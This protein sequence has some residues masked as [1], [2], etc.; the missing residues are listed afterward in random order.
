MNLRIAVATFAIGCSSVVY[1]QDAAKKADKQ[2]EKVAPAKAKSLKEVVLS[3]L[4]NH[5]QIKKL[6]KGRDVAYQDILSAQGSYLPT[7]D[8]RAAYGQETVQNQTVE[9]DRDHTRTSDTTESSLTI[10]QTLFDGGE[11]YGRLSRTR[12]LFD[13][14][15]NSIADG[16]EALAQRAVEAYI[17]VLKARKQIALS[18]QNIAAHK[19]ILDIVNKRFK[20]K[21]V[22]EADVV[23]VQG[24]LA[25]A[26]AQLR[27][28]IAGL[29]VTI[30]S[31]IEVTGE[32]PVELE[33]PGRIEKV[34][35]EDLKAAQNEA[36]TNHPSILANKD[37][38]KAVEAS[39]DEVYSRYY[40][41]FSLELSG[42]E[43]ENL[44]GVQENDDK[45]SIKL[46]MNWNL[47]RG[48]SDSADI[49]K[50]IFRREQETENLFETKRNLARDVAQ[51][52]YQ[53]IGRLE[54]LGFF[55]KHEIASGKTYEAYKSQYELGKQRTLFDLLNARSEF[56]RA[57]FNVI[58]AQYDI[59]NNE[60]RI[61]A[62]M[63]KLVEFFERLK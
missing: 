53:K 42:A 33:E 6:E 50:E 9:N 5:P 36:V 39:V 49:T 34:I 25:L 31:F 12:A 10:N 46:V 56:F 28:E 8:L 24:R 27:R 52:W 45:Y 51:A 29:K 17:S 30:A 48:G 59:I 15:I 7:V 37:T 61:L 1:S 22:P 20:N 23:Q 43:N 35:P 19:D 38:I 21:L 57:K 14:S 2:P 62:T 47:F 54:E 3:S 44:G 32:E 16:K 58:D 13:R 26:Q 60:Y 4:M 18:E 11:R 55:E 40:P 41:K 63:G